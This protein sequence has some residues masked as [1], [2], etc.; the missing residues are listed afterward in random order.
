MERIEW[1]Y[2]GSGICIYDATDLRGIERKWV[3]DRRGCVIRFRFT[4][5]R[6]KGQNE[7]QAGD[8][9]G[10]CVSFRAAGSRFVSL[11]VPYVFFFLHSRCL[12]SLAPARPPNQSIL[13]GRRTAVDEKTPW[14]KAPRA[15]REFGHPPALILSLT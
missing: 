7:P 8:Q 6:G 3:N 2:T 14:R 13:Q 15:L 9:I 5:R 4:K 10:S 11:S 1:L 12:P